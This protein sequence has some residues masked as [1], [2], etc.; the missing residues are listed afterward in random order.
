ML[1][2]DDLMPGIGCSIFYTDSS[3]PIWLI[4]LIVLIG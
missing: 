3:L 1:D 4:K 2:A